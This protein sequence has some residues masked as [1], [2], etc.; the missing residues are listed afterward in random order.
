M[1]KILLIDD[2]HQLVESLTI[3]LESEMFTVESV[4]N[5]ADARDRLR[6][7]DHDVIILDWSLP[8]SSGVEICKQFRATGKTTP[9]LMLTGRS[10]VED[11]EIGLDAG[12]DD[13]LTK[14]FSTRELLARVRA[15]LRRY[16]M[17]SSNIL[18]LDN[19]A[20]NPATREVSRN[21]RSIELLPREFAV[22]EFLM[23]HPNQVFTGQALLNHVWAAESDASVD[24]VRTCVMRLRKKLEQDDE[25][26]L[27]HTVYGVGYKIQAPSARK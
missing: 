8:D 15:L 10:E 26:P 4:F 11:K 25:A 22:L 3:L 9:V 7:Y 12:A 1:P 6:H 23:R 24:A 17:S 21:G 16:A 5:G 2:D 20:L 27:I 19:L 18:E 14:P 13:Y